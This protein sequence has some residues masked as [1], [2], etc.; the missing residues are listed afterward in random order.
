ME[1]VEVVI[2]N[3]EKG[4]FS[5]F[6]A[7]FKGKKIADYQVEEGLTFTLYECGWGD[8]DGYRVYKADERTPFTP[9]YDLVPHDADDPSAPNTEYYSLYEAK[10]IM[11]YYPMFAKH[12][13]LLGT[14]DIDPRLGR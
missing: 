10:E 4:T 3:C 11:A 1:W 12:I 5:G 9:E 13:E 14:R 2:G 8:Y 7:R 6:K